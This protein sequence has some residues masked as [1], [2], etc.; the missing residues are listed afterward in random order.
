MDEKFSRDN[1]HE[2]ISHKPTNLVAYRLMKIG[3]VVILV[4]YT[5]NI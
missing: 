4:C 2:A 5:Y 3:A 1:V